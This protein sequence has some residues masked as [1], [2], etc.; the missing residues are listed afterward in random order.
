MTHLDGDLGVKDLLAER[1]VVQDK[2]VHVQQ[3]FLQVVHRGELF[4][5]ALADVLRGRGGVVHRQVL[6][7]RLLGFKVFLVALRAGLT[8][9][10]H[11]QVGLE[12]DLETLEAG[13][14]QVALVAGVVAVTA[15]G[16]GGV[17]A[18]SVAFRGGD[19]HVGGGGAQVRHLGLTLV[20]GQRDVLVVLLD[21]LGE[22]EEGAE[23][24][25]VGAVGAG[26]NLGQ[27]QGSV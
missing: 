21:V 17:A 5:A 6:K 14:A 12:V 16:G 19:L 24:G 10:Q 23:D 11:L 8:P 1:A 22:L 27:R 2:R 18:Q 25:G 9:Q 13:E 4:I 7:Q 3:V 26:V 20:V 15:Q